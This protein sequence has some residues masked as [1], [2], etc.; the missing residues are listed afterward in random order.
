MIG[1]PCNE[2]VADR[3]QVVHRLARTAH[4]IIDL[5]YDEA[6]AQLVVI[7]RLAPTS[8][9]MHVARQR[10]PRLPARDRHCARIAGSSRQ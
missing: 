4:S 8:R 7:K 9:S 6:N 5:A 10:C 3:F 1:V 2:V